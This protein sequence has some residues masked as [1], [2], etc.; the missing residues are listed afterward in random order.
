MFQICVYMPETFLTLPAIIPFI[1]GILKENIII[2]FCQHFISFLLFF[3]SSQD[4]VAQN[5]VRAP[6]PHH[7]ESGKINLMRDRNT[8]FLQNAARVSM[9]R[10]VLF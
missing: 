8:E 6:P 5:I 10:H 1:T 4:T 2:H 7:Y 3:L 9:K